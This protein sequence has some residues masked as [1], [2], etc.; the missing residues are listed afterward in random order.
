[1][2]SLKL[3]HYDLHHDSSLK[4]YLKCISWQY[5]SKRKLDA[6]DLVPSPTKYYKYFIAS[7]ITY[8]QMKSSK[9]LASSPYTWMISNV[10]RYH[11]V[12]ES[13][14]SQSCGKYYLGI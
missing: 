11:P 1:M 6:V 8:T 3:T 9:V 7:Y 5:N 14:H 12:K 13:I 2:K 10:V 4:K